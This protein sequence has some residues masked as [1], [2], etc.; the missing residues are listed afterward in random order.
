MKFR[1]CMPTECTKAVHS[2]VRDHT[3]WVNDKDIYAKADSYRYTC[4]LTP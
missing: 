2:Y 4:I 3:Q 1:F